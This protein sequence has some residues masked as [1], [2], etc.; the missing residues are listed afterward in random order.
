MKRNRILFSAAVALFGLTARQTIAAP[1]TLTFEGLQNF[2]SVNNYYD[3]LFGADN[4]NYAGPVSGPGPNYGIIFT[5][6]TAPGD[7]GGQALQETAA[8]SNFMHEPSSQTILFDLNNDEIDM[9]DVVG[10]TGPLSLWYTGDAAGALFDS[11]V[12]SGLG[13]PIAPTFV[14]DTLG[15]TGAP[16][17]GEPALA[18]IGN[19]VELPGIP[20][21]PM[22]DPAKG[23]AVVDN[24]VWDHVMIGFPGTAYGAKFT[25][26]GNH[27]GMDDIT[28]IQAPEPSTMLMLGLGIVGVVA[29]CR[30]RRFMIAP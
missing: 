19:T 10:F 15:Y 7:R 30:R 21:S 29:C 3:G 13:G 27:F 23:N 18:I 1:V 11:I 20:T 28:L 8:L 6:P 25:G 9:G 17:A 16:P 14:A 12:I 4:A 26:A 2:E 24:T 5:T 22:P